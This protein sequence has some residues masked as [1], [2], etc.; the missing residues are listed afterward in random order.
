MT[1]KTKATHVANSA[2]LAMI[3]EGTPKRAKTPK[4]PRNQL[5]RNE[6]VYVNRP[7]LRNVVLTLTEEVRL[8]KSAWAWK[9]T[10]L[11]AWVDKRGV[12]HVT[13]GIAIVAEWEME[14][15]ADMESAA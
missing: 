9:A 15:V 10:Y 4:L 5:F 7:G 6:R 12:R 2:V 13:R 14:V 8:G 1:H 11:Q 3:P